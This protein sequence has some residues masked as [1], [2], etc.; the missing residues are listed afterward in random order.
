[1]T[2]LVRA[3]SVTEALDGIA[4]GEGHVLAGGQA[5]TIL[6]I[7]GFVDAA[8]LID[9]AGLDELRQVTRHPGHVRI[10]ALCTHRAVGT[11]T[12][13]A[14]AVPG[15]G[16]AFTSIG[17]VR[18]R[19]AGTLG[20]NLAHADPRQD[21]PPALVLLDAVAVIRGPDA[22]RTVAVAD[23]IDGALSTTLAHDEL[24]TAVDVPVLREQEWFGF[25]KFLAG[26]SEGFAT[27]NAALRL[28][29][30]D[31]GSL[32]RAEACIGAVGA[33]PQRM[34]LSPLVD[35]PVTALADLADEA[36]FAVTDALDPA[37]ARP[38]SGDH[39]RA[40]CGELVRDLLLRAADDALPRRAP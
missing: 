39:L 26:S 8:R 20:G 13:V 29:W 6:L 19:A 24:I 17:N 28:A 23:L 22:T 33:V 7:E 36:F 40:L 4:D 18:V 35:T 31:D 34:T 16:E 14:D 15:L 32:D 3:R 5:L 9:L 1:M 38:T 27:A 12:T 21:P 11:D 2:E 30:A 37:D 10:G 25:S